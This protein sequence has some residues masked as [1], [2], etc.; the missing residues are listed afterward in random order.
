MYKQVFKCLMGILNENI[1]SPSY[2]TQVHP[3][4]TTPMQQSNVNSAQLDSISKV[5][6]ITV[7]V[8]I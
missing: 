2:S 1:R 4:S 6:N 8:Q 3:S 7:D 5:Y